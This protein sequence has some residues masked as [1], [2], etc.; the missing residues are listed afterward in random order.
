MKESLELNEE[1]KAFAQR[2]L[3]EHLE[4]KEDCKAILKENRDMKEKIVALEEQLTKSLEFSE[5][6]EAFAKRKLK[7]HTVKTLCEIGLLLPRVPS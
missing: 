6:S 2:K 5:E 1:R 3:K 4:L 7:G